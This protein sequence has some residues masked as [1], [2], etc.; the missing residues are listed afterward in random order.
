MRSVTD[1]PSGAVWMADNLDGNH[2]EHDGEG[3]ADLGI[4]LERIGHEIK[5]A[6]GRCPQQA[7]GE[8][9]HKGIFFSASLCV[10]TQALLAGIIPESE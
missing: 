4:K 8:E 6:W 2:G 1:A 7:S 3:N 5:G 9:N 10:L